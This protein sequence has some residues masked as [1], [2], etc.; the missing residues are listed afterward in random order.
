MIVGL[1]S[2]ELNLA[3]PLPNLALVS[4]LPGTS[5]VN[6]QTIPSFG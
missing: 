5:G 2:G 4:Q 3:Q 6:L 1:K